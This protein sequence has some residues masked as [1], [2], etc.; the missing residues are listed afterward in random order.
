MKKSD[1]SMESV[2]LKYGLCMASVR[3]VYVY[4]MGEFNSPSLTSVIRQRGSWPSGLL[5]TLRYISV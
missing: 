2:W 1:L 5:V 3:I 4:C